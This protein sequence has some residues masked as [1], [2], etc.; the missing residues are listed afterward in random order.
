MIRIDNHYYIKQYSLYAYLIDLFPSITMGFDFRKLRSVYSGNAIRV[1]RTSDN[2]ERDFPF[3]ANEVVGSDVLDFVGWN[4][5][6]YSEELQQSV[7]TKTNLTVTA[8]AVVAPDGTTTGGILFETVT[9]ALHQF[10]RNYSL[11]N[12]NEYT[13]SFWIKN[14][15]RNH[16]RILT[17][18][19]F[20]QDGTTPLAWLDLST[21]TIVSQTSGFTGSDLTITA[22]GSWYRVSYTMPALATSSINVLQLSLSANGSNVSYIGDIAKGVAVWGLQITQSDTV[23][24][25]DKTEATARGYGS[26]SKGYDQASGGDDVINATI[27]RQPIIVNNG[28]LI[29][30][31]GKLALQGGSTLG[32]R[33]TS[34]VAL[35]GYTDLFFTFGVNILNI[36][37]V[38][39]EILFETSSNANSN[40]GAIVI[41]LATS[42]VILVTQRNS[43]GLFSQKSYPI[44][45]GRQ[46]ITVRFRTGQTASD[47]SQVWINGTEITGTVTVA[48]SSTALSNQIIYLFARNSNSNGFLGKYQNF[49]M[50][51]D[52]GQRVGIENNIN[53]YH[54]YY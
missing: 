54:G 18:S 47:A 27:I 31:G 30:D 7:W 43:S 14:E 44:S 48:N 42:S 50:F 34:T 53:D 11:I 22:D 49:T 32:L 21:G 9:N 41:T 1:L 12:G 35:S 15:G 37:T 4:L 28:N 2:T 16:V 6:S 17:S 33:S 19:N 46:L 13:V 52:K 10:S 39:N 26:I 40:N 29:T 51:T 23:L 25:Y 20:S 5:W 36:P 38:S 3:V 45:A 8:N 24:D